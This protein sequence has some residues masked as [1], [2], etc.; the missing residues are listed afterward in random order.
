MSELLRA[1]ATAWNL[2]HDHPWL[3]AVAGA[4]LLIVFVLRSPAGGA[5]SSRDPRRTFTAAERAHAFQRAGMRCEHKSMFWVRCT[6][7][8]TQGDHVFPWSQ[9]GR[10]AMSNQQALC[11][12]HNNRKSGAVPTR[13]YILRLQRRRRRYFPSGE[14][15]RI[16]WRPGAAL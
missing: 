8:A 12:F 11:A 16:E 2:L 15:A 7:T 10:T 13:M 3:L 5:C 14:Q 1:A 4:I 9:G 6:N